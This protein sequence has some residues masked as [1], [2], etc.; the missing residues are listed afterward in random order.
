MGQPASLDLFARQKRAGEKIVVLTAYDLASARTA[1]AGGVDAL[2]VGDSLGNV[3]LGHE[4]TLPVTV[5]DM[6]HHTAPVHAGAPPACRSSPT[7]RTAASTSTPPTPCA[8]PCGWCKEAGAHAVKLEGGRKREAHLRALLDAEIPVMGHLGLTPQSVTRF[9]GY[10]VQGRGDAAAA[11]ILDDAR[12]LARRRLLRDRARVRAGDPRGAHH[13]RRRRSRPSASAPA[14]AATARCWSS[15]TCW[16]C[17]PSGSRSSCGATPS[18]AAL[19]AEAVA[20]YAADVRAGGF[21]GPEHAFGD[22]NGQ[23]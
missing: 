17:S 15:T 3:I 11:A 4:T 22:E 9:G 12:F 2:L 16:A 8:P 5:D 1:A 19:A 7:C 21:P 14:P 6:V 10:K 13:G 18:W 20:A 23:A